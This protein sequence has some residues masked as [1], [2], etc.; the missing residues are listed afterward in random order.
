[1]YMI[2]YSRVR[3]GIMFILLEEFQKD[4]IVEVTLVSSLKQWLKGKHF[5]STLECSKCMCSKHYMQFIMART[6]ECLE[7]MEGNEEIRLR[8]KA[9]GRAGRKALCAIL[10]GWI[11]LIIKNCLLLLDFLQ[12]LSHLIFTPAIWDWYLSG[13][14]TDENSRDQSDY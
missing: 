13:C 5:I 12:M 11:L 4:F 3:K 7:K 2:Q 9:V 1:M 6:R 10:R 8:K 14:F